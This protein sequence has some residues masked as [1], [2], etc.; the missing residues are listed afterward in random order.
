[1]KN[2][3]KIEP[4]TMEYLQDY[5]REFTEEIAKY[6]WPDP[7]ETLEDA[8]HLLK[9]FLEEMERGETLLL[10]ALSEEGEFFGS[11]EV[12]GLTE[13]CPELGVWI[14]KSQWGKGYAYEALKAALDIARTKYG[15]KVF[16]YEADVRNV[17][18]MKLLRKFESEYEITEQ[19][20]EKLTTDS[21][22]KLELQ[23]FIMR[24]K[25]DD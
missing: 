10:V 2:K 21:G 15:K 8:E 3:I 11:S 12:H 24:V 5:Y 23:G 4:F 25:E 17:G 7:F 16:F 20:V 18:S 9:E 6:Q 1:M 13:D 22:K 19:D 14:K